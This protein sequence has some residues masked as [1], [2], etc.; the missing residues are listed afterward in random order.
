MSDLFGGLD[1]L[2]G[3][4]PL[5]EVNRMGAGLGEKYLEHDYDSE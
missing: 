2:W 5:I 1:L 3:S 4:C